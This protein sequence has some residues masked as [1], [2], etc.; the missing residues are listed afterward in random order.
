[1]D[2]LAE[3]TDLRNL[4]YQGEGQPGLPLE[5]QVREEL[6]EA[7][8][9]DFPT[10]Q[11]QDQAEN[12]N[13]ASEDIGDELQTFTGLSERALDATGQ[14][15]DEARSN[16]ESSAALDIA[17]R[18]SMLLGRMKQKHVCHV[19]GRECPSKH[20]LKRHLSTHS[21][22]RPFNCHVCGKSFKWTEYLA[23]HM[24]QQHKGEGAL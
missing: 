22:E 21:E 12:T 23:K 7:A 9:H 15:S 13:I 24:R 14:L 4:L 8:P 6:T 19:C 20:K 17:T 1:M 5:L 2:S 16:L 11:Q 18:R 3:Q 10:P